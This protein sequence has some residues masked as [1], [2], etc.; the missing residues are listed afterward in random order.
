MIPK[1]I[2]L[3]AIGFFWWILK[4]DVA[5]RKGVSGAIWIP[6]LWVAIISS[7]PLSMWFAYGGGDS[8]L[9]G[10]PLDRLGFFF[11]ICAAWYVLLRR[12][13][14]WG[15]V[16]AENWAVFLFYGFL[17]LSVL[18]ANS[19][20]V[21]FKRWFKEFGNILVALVILTESDPQEALRAVFVRCGC[22]LLPLSEIFIRWFPELGRR[23]NIHNGEMEAI[24]VTGQK[25]AL[26]AL[27]LVCGLMLIWDLLER[28]WRNKRRLSR[29]DRY[30]PLA[31]LALGVYLIHLCDSKT[32]L[33]CL[34]LGACIL[35]SMRL[36]LLRKRVRILGF[37]VLAAVLLFFALD[38]LFGIKEQ[39]V[40]SLGRDMTFTGRTDV[41]RE[42]LDVHTDPLLGTGFMSFWDD[43][44]YQSRLP[45]WVA[46]SA[47]NGYLEVY[48]AG[49]FVGVFFLAVMLL[50]SGLRINRALSWGGDY[51]VVR[52]AL[53][54]IVLLANFSESNFACMSPVGFLFLVAAIGNVRTAWVL[55][56][57]ASAPQLPPGHS[58]PAAQAVG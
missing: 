33:A 18:W 1:L 10:S 17:L 58:E 20:L 34:A 57:G 28:G 35:A 16:I 46:F 15:S 51:A 42:L 29:F 24:G 25:N 38:S 11:L 13:V 31:V 19:P 22:V 21:S 48:L 14:D 3:A 52:L 50:A 7:R 5:L 43:K 39:I 37:C 49:G 30:L 45:Y 2:L 54:V 27:V 32:S 36:P 23:Y 55:D 44:H 56:P 12:R 4:R 26:G 41:W 47:H 6:T 9:E 40:R 8:T 53:L